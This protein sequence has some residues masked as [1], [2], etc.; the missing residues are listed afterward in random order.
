MAFY[1][2]FRR[3]ASRQISNLEAATSEVMISII[4][5]NSQMDIS[6]KE[7]EA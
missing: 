7:E 5:M 3:R 1:A 4:G 2:W 6:E